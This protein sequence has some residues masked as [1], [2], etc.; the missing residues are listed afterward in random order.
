MFP[1]RLELIPWWVL[2]KIEYIEFAFFAFLY[3]SNS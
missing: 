2:K 1:L 3:K